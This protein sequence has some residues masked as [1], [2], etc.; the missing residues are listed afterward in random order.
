MPNLM[1]ALHHMITVTG[2][3]WA[4]DVNQGSSASLTGRLG[5]VCPVY[6]WSEITMSNRQEGSMVSSYKP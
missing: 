2:P 5:F 3:E 4:A 6:I 1:A